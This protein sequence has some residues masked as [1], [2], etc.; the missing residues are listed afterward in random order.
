MVVPFLPLIAQGAGLVAGGIA[1]RKAQ[2][3]AEKRSLEE[4][5]ALAA[6][7]GIGGTLGSYGGQFLQTGQQALAGPQRY[8]ETLLH[9]N[10]A[11]MTQAVAPE[12][13]QITAASR[14][15]E[16][17]LDRT[18]VRGAAREQANVEAARQQQAAVAALMGA[19]RP[20]AAEALAGIGESMIGQGAY[21]SAQA[22]NLQSSLLSEGFANRQYA[23][24]EGRRTSEAI[25]RF[26][27]EI[28]PNIPK[29]QPRPPG[30]YTVMD[31]NTGLPRRTDI[32]GP[33]V[34]P[35]PTGYGP[36]V[37]PPPTARAQPYAYATAGQ[38]AAVSPRPYR[39]LF[40][41]PPLPQAPGARPNVSTYT[42]FLPTNQQR[43][44]ISP[45]YPGP[46]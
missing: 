29:R 9:G 30:P 40:G 32:S 11:A 1:G 28:I 38:Q 23:R 36:P 8:Y 34:T 43:L 20:R 14:G 44:P 19:V 16:R 12:V 2:R 6:A 27:R 46:Y 26:V 41:T 21:A 45:L 22:G 37:T 35:P 42:S 25:G 5:Q 31:E 3:D 13:A 39:S 18:G 17:N 15:S 33:P 4:Q 24:D 10:R 7:R